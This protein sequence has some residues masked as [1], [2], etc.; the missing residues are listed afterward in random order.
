MH[1]LDESFTVGE[2]DNAIGYRIH[3]FYRA[4]RIGNSAS[5]AEADGTFLVVVLTLSNPQDQSITLPSNSIRANSENPF[6]YLDDEAS[7]KLSSDDRIDAS[8]LANTTVLSGASKM[9]AIVF[10]VPASGTYR[11]EIMPAG[12]DEPVHVVEVGPISDVEKLQSTVVG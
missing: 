6:Q 1:E 3:N 12:A 9:G 11:I 7:S 8:S 5:Y 10:D 2:G 4:D